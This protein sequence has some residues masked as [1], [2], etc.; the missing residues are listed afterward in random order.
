MDCFKGKRWGSIEDGWQQTFRDNNFPVPDAKTVLDFIQTSST[1][2]AEF[3]RSL[4]LFTP[5]LLTDLKS[6][7]TELTGL[8][9]TDSNIQRAYCCFT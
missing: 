2:R 6:K 1:T 4:E 7:F 5:Q 9:S 3:N 8:D